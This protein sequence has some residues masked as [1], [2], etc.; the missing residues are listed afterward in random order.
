MITIP[1]AGYFHQVGCESV[2]IDSNPING[3][4]Y[5]FEMEVHFRVSFVLPVVGFSAEK[6]PVFLEVVCN[7]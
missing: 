5:F 6:V 3:V 1:P 7:G 2:K 4:E